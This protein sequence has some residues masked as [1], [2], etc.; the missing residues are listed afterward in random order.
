MQ[1][2]E[3]LQCTDALPHRSSQQF[4]TVPKVLDFHEERLRA[5]LYCR[6]P[7]TLTTPSLR[8][9]RGRPTLRRK[10][11]ITLE[12]FMDDVTCAGELFCRRSINAL[13]QSESNTVTSGIFALASNNSTT[14]HHGFYNS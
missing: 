8:L 1:N 14:C 11:A 7:S 5:T 3:S 12:S 4:N 10:F 13:Q 9:V 2:H 6:W